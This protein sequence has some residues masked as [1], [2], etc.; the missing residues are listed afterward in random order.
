MDWV[1]Y[2]LDHEQETLQAWV[3]ATQFDFEAFI[4]HAEPP[5]MPEKPPSDARARARKG[6]GSERR[7]AMRRP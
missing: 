6:C 4:C 5:A 3:Q 7:R 1:D 2:V